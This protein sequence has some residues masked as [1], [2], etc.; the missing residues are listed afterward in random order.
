M[1]TVYGPMVAKRSTRVD[2]PVKAAPPHRQ[3]PAPTSERRVAFATLP[4]RFFLGV[5]FVGSRID[6]FGD[7]H[8]PGH[9]LGVQSAAESHHQQPRGDADVFIS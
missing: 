1:L 9:R 2:R 4:L 5:T 3:V 7:Y 8:F 6:R